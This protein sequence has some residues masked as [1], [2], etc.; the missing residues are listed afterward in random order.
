MPVN[1]IVRLIV[2][3]YQFTSRKSIGIEVGTEVGV[4]VGNAVGLEVG[5]DVGVKVG[6]EEVGQR[7]V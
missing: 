6:T 1:I 4:E 3:Q 2:K 5:T 7:L